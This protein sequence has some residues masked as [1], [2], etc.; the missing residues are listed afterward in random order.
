[1]KHWDTHPDFVEGC[2]GCR[3]TT[4]GTDIQGLL[5][6]NRGGDVTN[7]RGTREYVRDMYAKRRAAGL[8]DPEPSNAKSAAFAPARGV[9]R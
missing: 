3:L 8:P 6:E 7:G 9:V 4:V 1:M 5:L 2:Y